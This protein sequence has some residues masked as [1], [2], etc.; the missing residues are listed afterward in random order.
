MGSA[1]QGG[2]AAAASATTSAAT[3]AAGATIAAAVTTSKI[4]TA[5]GC[6]VGR[7]LKGQKPAPEGSRAEGVTL[8]RCRAREDLWVSGGEMWVIE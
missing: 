6:S 2:V 7:V 3:V 5:A 8:Q 4:S 1:P